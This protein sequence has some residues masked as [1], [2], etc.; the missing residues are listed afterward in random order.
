MT[1][2]AA[3]IFFGESLVSFAIDTPHRFGCRARVDHVPRDAAIA[4]VGERPFLDL[5]EDHFCAPW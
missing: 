2:T 1:H 4:V 5:G 3:S